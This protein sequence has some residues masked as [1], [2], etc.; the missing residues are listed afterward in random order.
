ML[1]IKLINDSMGP[2]RSDN[3][4]PLQTNASKCGKNIIINSL[5]KKKS[6]QVYILDNIL[7]VNLSINIFKNINKKNKCKQL[8]SSHF[9]LQPVMIMGVGRGWFVV[10]LY[11]VKC[12]R[13]GLFICQKANK[14]NHSKSI[15]LIIKI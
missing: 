9:G 3:Q 5:L 1:W 12:K 6:S 10:L 15:S 4:T 13:C 7:I 2:R 14:K 8:F 11:E